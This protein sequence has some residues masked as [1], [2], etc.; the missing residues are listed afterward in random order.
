LQNLDLFQ[1]TIEERLHIVTGIG[2][3]S[4]KGSPGFAEQHIR[5][6]FAGVP[7]VQELR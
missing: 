1:E 7:E 3:K 4:M 5:Q 6:L 2:G